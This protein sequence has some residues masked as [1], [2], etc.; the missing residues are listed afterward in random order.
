LGKGKGEEPTMQHAILDSA[1]NLVVSYE[2]ELL[3]R[4]VFHAIVAVESDAAEH[5]VLLAYDDD[6][7]PVGDAR[8]IVDVPPAFD[9]EPSPYAQV[10]ATTATVREPLGVRTWDLR[11]QLPT[12]TAGVQRS[13]PVPT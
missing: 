3:A 4:A 5:L 8:T 13:D 1:G 12:W 7:M 10:E 6:G 9:V 2:D 11:A